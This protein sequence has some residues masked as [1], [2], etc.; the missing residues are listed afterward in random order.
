[1]FECQFGILQV[2]EQVRGQ[3][4]SRHS[5]RV[6]CQTVP[7]LVLHQ[8]NQTLKLFLEKVMREVF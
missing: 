4:G 3:F 7:Q 8:L 5:A 6:H 2:L 1:M